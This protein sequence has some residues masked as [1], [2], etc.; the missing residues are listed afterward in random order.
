MIKSLIQLVNIIQ[1]NK[2]YT[3]NNEWFAFYLVA[4]QFLP[5]HN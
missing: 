3:M 2:A 1:E 4:K 5:F